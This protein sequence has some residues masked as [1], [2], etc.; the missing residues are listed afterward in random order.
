MGRSGLTDA[1]AKDSAAQAWSLTKLGLLFCSSFS[2]LRS[3]FTS[4][5][6]VCRQSIRSFDI[7]VRAYAKSSFAAGSRLTARERTTVAAFT[8]GKPLG[9][10]L[11]PL[12]FP[13]ALFFFLCV[14][15]F[16]PRV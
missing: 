9:G 2:D 14:W 10:G 6:Q 16:V 13:P 4:V 1:E 12:A 5:S 15:N 8:A 3:S 7:S 11:T